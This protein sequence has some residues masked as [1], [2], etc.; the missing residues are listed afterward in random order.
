M[1]THDIVS[2]LETGWVYT[3]LESPRHEMG[4]TGTLRRISRRYFGM[5][6]G[7]PGVWRSKDGGKSWDYLARGTTYKVG[8]AI[9]DSTI[10]VG[11]EHSGGENYIHRFIDDGTSGPFETEIVH[12]FPK[13]FGQ[14]V[15][16]GRV[17]PSQRDYK[18]L[19][20]TANASGPTGT[21]QLLISKDGEQWE[22]ID[23]KDDVSPRR[24]FYYLSHH[25]RDGNYY[26]CK[27]PLSVVIRL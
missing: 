22:V 18:F 14:P 25:P 24:S 21:A 10:Y 6:Y 11:S 13:D 2:S 8:L 16:S 15:M 23:K 5:V 9:D 17:I 3:V 1:H 27:Y 19:Y 20:S 7:H 4:I 26:A 12:V